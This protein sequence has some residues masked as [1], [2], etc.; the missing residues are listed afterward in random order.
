M[1]AL[2]KAEK[3][4]STLIEATRK[5]IQGGERVN[6]D[7]LSARAQLYAVRQELAQARYEWLNAW[8]ELHYYAGTLDET[9]LTQL[10]GYFSRRQ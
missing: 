1:A 5:S 8:A 2:Q 7:L 4:A 9:V 6:L 3:S 10:A